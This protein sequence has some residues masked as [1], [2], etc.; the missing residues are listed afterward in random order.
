M[1]SEPRSRGSQGLTLVE[2]LVVL[3]IIGL[4]TAVAVPNLGTVIRRSSASSPGEELAHVLRSVRSEAARRG[5]TVCLELNTVS[6]EFRVVVRDGAGDSLLKL[7][8]LKGAWAVP[9]MAARGPGALI[10]YDPLGPAVP[11]GRW[12]IADDESTVL[13]I[14]G[15]DGSVSV[16]R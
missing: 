6:R 11:S 4:A 14:D 12:S 15:W 2:L 7:G 16:D 5:R 3:A 13:E 9:E 8:A 10:C 1:E